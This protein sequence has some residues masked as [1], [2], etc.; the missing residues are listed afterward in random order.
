M[1]SLIPLSLLL[2]SLDVYATRIPFKTRIAKRASISGGNGEVS[3]LNTQNAEYI[4]N[5]TL[6]G[7][8]IPVLLDTG[9]YEHRCW[10]VEL[11]LKSRTHA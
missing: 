8:N 6:G 4:A 5:I 1:R 2:F 9:R 11:A 3:M 10:S 7:R